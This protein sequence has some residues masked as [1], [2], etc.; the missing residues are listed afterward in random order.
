M[1]TSI[2]NNS[3]LVHVERAC[4]DQSMGLYFNGILGVQM[5]PTRIC[6]FEDIKHVT[7]VDEIRNR[8]NKSLEYDITHYRVKN[9]YGNREELD[10]CVYKELL[11]SI[12]YIELI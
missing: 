8:I 4:E 6:F 7:Q 3:H 11:N 1:I 10:R 5:L 9:T 12:Y 2:N